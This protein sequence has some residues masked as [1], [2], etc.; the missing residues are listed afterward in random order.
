MEKIIKEISDKTLKE[1]KKSQKLPYP[2]YY[3]EVFNFL[4]KSE[5]VYS[6]IN[7]L[8]L[9]E[10]DTSL[11]QKV[12]DT[13]HTKVKDISK[14]SNELK[15]DSKKFADDLSNATTRELKDIIAHFN[16]NLLNK[17]EQMQNKI[18]DLEHELEHAYNELLLDHLTKVYNRKAL[19]R[20]LNEAL[21]RGKDHD[22]D[23][24]LAIIDL[25][26]FKEVNDKYGHLVGDFVLIKLADVIKKMIRDGDK[27]YRYGGDELIIVFN[28]VNKESVKR[29]MQRII[30]KISKTTLKYKDNLIKITVSGGIAL[31]KEGDDMESLIRRADK[32]LYEAKNEKNTI[33]L[34]E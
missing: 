26:N 21:Q 34:E 22:L 24:A 7:P 25:D 12:V 14:T 6:D 29:I 31:H 16:N 33:K 1:L 19:E 13:A 15:E 11:A 5:G 18:N 32:A 3:K 28:R 30:D 8:L 10:S 23:L 17:I 9:C 27:V 2:L 4:A 20:D